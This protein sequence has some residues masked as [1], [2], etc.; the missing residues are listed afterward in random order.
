MG[1]TL[2][3]SLQTVNRSQDGLDGHRRELGEETQD[4]G[5]LPFT[6]LGTPSSGLVTALAETIL[7]EQSWRRRS[8][9]KPGPWSSLQQLSSARRLKASRQTQKWGALRP[10]LWT[11]GIHRV[12]LERL[13]LVDTRSRAP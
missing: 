3:N 8:S 2:I 13:G 1:D 5:G 12:A 9:E 10:G 4:P 6:N 11:G 7:L